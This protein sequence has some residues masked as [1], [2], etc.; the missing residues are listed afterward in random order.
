MADDG[1]AAGVEPTGMMGWAKVRGTMTSVAAAP[2]ETWDGF[3]NVW[4]IHVR[5]LKHENNIYRWNGKD[6]VGVPAI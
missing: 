5:Q 6:R 1:V 4:G 2:G 3:R